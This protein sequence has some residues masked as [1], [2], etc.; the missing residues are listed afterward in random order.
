MQYESTN[1]TNRCQKSRCRSAQMAKTAGYSIGTFVCRRFTVLDSREGTGLLWR[2]RRSKATTVVVSILLCLKPSNICFSMGS[3]ARDET[4]C[5]FMFRV[6]SARPEPGTTR[7][8]CTFTTATLPC[9]TIKHYGE[10]TTM[11]THMQ[12]QT[13]SS[14]ARCP[15]RESVWCVPSVSS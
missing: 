8:C 10:S 7:N 15:W 5:V 2:E 14:T 4:Y 3:M 6:H 11:L 12:Q 9:R 13:A 1:H